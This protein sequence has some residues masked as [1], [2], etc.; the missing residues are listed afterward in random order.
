MPLNAYRVPEYSVLGL[1][2][3]VAAAYEAIWLMAMSFGASI[4]SVD[5][6]YLVFYPLLILPLVVFVCVS[7]I[8]GFISFVCYVLIGMLAGVTSKYDVIFGSPRASGISFIPWLVF[9]LVCVSFALS[10]WKFPVDE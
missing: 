10:R 7:R 3:L 2:V 6:A 8:Q 9:A 4:T 5:E 1:A